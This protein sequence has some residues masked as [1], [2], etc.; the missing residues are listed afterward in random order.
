MITRDLEHAITN[1]LSVVMGFVDMAILEEDPN[2]RHEW[3]SS[4]KKVIRDIAIMMDAHRR[5]GEHGNEP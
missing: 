2:K 5:M 1:K 4:S 3:L